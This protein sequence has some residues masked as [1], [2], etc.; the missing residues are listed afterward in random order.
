MWHL[1]SVRPVSGRRRGA[2]GSESVPSCPRTSMLSISGGEG[3]HPHVFA[4]S[5]FANVHAGQ[6]SLRV[7][8]RRLY[9][10]DLCVCVAE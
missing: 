7:D 3:V 1:W 4:S 6:W 10:R 8:V 2:V 9:S 5:Q